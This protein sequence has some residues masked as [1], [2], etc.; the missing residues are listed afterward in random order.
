MAAL[1]E[2]VKRFIVQALAC[3]DS[4]KTVSDAV[5]EEFGLT[6]PRQQ[7]ETYDPTRVAGKSLSQRWRV[8][9]EQTREEWKKG[10]AEVPIANRVHR[11][12][13][14]QR[15]ATKA[16]DMKNIALALQVLE[17]AAKEVGDIY[18]N[19][20]RVGSGQD[21]S[22]DEPV[23]TKVIRGVKDARRHDDG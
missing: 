8:V 3:Y 15:F 14:L 23:P 16:A 4:P 19:K 22:G 21:G 11:L 10:V 6:V 12:R 18:V 5:K 20:G 1:S 13:M 17:Q 9:F 7:V 2:D